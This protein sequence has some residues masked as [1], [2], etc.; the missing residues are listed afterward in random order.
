MQAGEHTSH[1]RLPFERLVYGLVA[2]NLL[3]LV[4]LAIPVIVFGT[5]VLM[6]HAASLGAPSLLLCLLGAA[7][8]LAAIISAALFMWAARGFL[9]FSR[10]RIVIT[11]IGY[12]IYSWIAIKFGY[13]DGYVALCGTAITAVVFVRSLVNGPAGNS[14][15]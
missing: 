3:C 13:I 2:L 1:F 4:W 6:I 12:L 15:A 10:I 7:G 14:D 8:A 11:G 9:E 5:V